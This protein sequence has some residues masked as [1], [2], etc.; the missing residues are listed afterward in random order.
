M[1][2]NLFKKIKAIFLPVSTALK[3]DLLPLRSD[4]TPLEFD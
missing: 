2:I 1:I 4:P 3:N